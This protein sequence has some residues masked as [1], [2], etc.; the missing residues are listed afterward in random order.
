[1][2]KTLIIVVAALVAAVFVLAGCAQQPGPGTGSQGAPSGVAAAPGSSAANTSSAQVRLQDT[3]YWP[4]AY[5]ISG[6]VTSP[7]AEAALA[8]FQVVR[9]MQPDG[10]LQVTLKALQ[11]EYHDQSYVVQP[12]QQ[13][14]FIETS[15]GDDAGGQEYSLRDDTAVLT[16]ANGY[17]IQS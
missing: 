3:Q 14:Y 12:G 6:N 7:Q 16:D 8:G 5:L 1:M 15:M 17:I 4:Y 2:K 11:P 13:L 10:S 9:T